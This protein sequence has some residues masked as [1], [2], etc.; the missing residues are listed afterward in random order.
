MKPEIERKWR[1]DPAP[2]L[3]IPVEH[4]ILQG[5]LGTPDNFEIRVRC[6]GEDEFY[7]C[8]KN[9]ENLVRMEWEVPIPKEV[10]GNFW[11]LVQNYLCKKRRVV[12]HN[13]YRLEI[14]FYLG[15]LYGLTIVECEFV[16]EEEALAFELPEWLASCAVE[17]TDDPR[18]KNR[19]LAKLGSLKELSM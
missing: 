15:R 17:V 10:W 1:L 18:Y 13:G 11:D 8:S 19:N 14:D 4:S 7:L 5:Y 9:S 16:S 12:T 3:D 6:V 2:K